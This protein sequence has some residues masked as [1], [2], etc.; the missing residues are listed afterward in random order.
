MLGIGEHYSTMPIIS[1]KDIFDESWSG[2]SVEVRRAQPKRT[3]RV[4]SLV[5]CMIA[6]T[7]IAALVVL[8]AD[9]DGLKAER[10]SHGDYFDLVRNATGGRLLWSLRGPGGMVA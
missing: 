10:R 2:A 3:G 4:V 8:L 5:V 9:T 6:A 7:I 1:R